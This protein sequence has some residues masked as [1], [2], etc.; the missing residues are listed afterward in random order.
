MYVFKLKRIGTSSF[1]DI[2]PEFNS[3]NISQEDKQV[4]S[5]MNITLKNTPIGAEDE[6]V[7]LQTV[8]ARTD[9]ETFKDG[10]S[11]GTQSVAFRGRVKQVSTETIDGN[12]YYDATIYEMSYELNGIFLENK[13]YENMT[14]ADIIND[15]LDEVEKK[16]IGISFVRDINC[17]ITFSKID[18]SDRSALE[19]LEDLATLTGYNYG[20]RSS[21]VC[22]VDSAGEVSQ[23]DDP[24]GDFSHEIRE[25]ISFNL[26]T[27]ETSLDVSDRILANTINVDEDSASI[28]NRFIILGG[29]GPADSERTDNAN[30]ITPNEYQLPFEYEGTPSI[31]IRPDGST[32]D[33]SLSSGNEYSISGDR[34]SF[35]ESE[36]HGIIEQSVDSNTR[37]T[38]IELQ[39]G[40]THDSLG[41]RFHSQGIASNTSGERLRTGFAIKMTDANSAGV[42]SLGDGEFLNSI[43]LYIAN[44]TFGSDA[45]KI[46]AWY[47]EPGAQ[48]NIQMVESVVPVRRTI[49]SIS[50]D[51]D[52][53]ADDILNASETLSSANY[54][55]AMI[56]EANFS[57][58]LIGKRGVQELYIE[59]ELNNITGQRLNADDFVLVNDRGSADLYNFQLFDVSRNA[60]LDPYRDRTEYEI[61]ASDVLNDSVA[62]FGVNLYLIEDN[63]ET[64]LFRAVV[65]RTSGDTGIGSD[66]IIKVNGTP[67]I[68]Q[69]KSFIRQA[70]ITK[71]GEKTSFENNP[72]IRSDSDFTERAKVIFDKNAEP[73]FFGSIKTTDLLRDNPHVAG[74]SI[75]ELRNDVIKVNDVIQID[76]DTDGTPARKFYIETINSVYEGESGGVQVYTHTI[77]INQ[78]KIKNIFQIIEESR[79][80]IQRTENQVSGVV[81]NN[82]QDIEVS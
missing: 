58:P 42:G 36:L 78:T 4:N 1:T 12:I 14:V 45:F 43:R 71:Y 37:A 41:I 53:V 32:V 20:I 19:I 18:A 7:V 54:N 8:G 28:I 80:R 68:K 62:E 40:R 39:R 48:N 79:R 64:P 77:E 17:D 29:D 31:T 82:E 27:E 25:A 11:Q 65:S 22:D 73:V 5:T 52:D 46:N 60:S 6:L 26:I 67:I 56:L 35:N 24:N 69:R 61:E 76:P 55:D 81:I 49:G 51:E 30:R 66:D 63:H 2:N 44:N 74:S 59:L 10:T 70:S 72:D 38:N 33:Y 75:Q 47:V 13:V 21:F 50:R 15:V 3:P 57:T 16:D 34:I 9:G 23:R